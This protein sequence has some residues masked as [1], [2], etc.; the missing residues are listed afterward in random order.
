[1]KPIFH[2]VQRIDK[3]WGH[4]RVVCNNE[5]YCG[6]F[7]HFIK[8]SKFSL[9]AH[10]KKRETFFVLYGKLLL[11]TIN[12]ETAE[13]EYEELSAGNVVEIPR[14][15]P[16]QISALETSEI[17]EFSTHHEDSDSYRYEKGD[18]QR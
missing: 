2:E 5:E 11:R 4:E 6:K 9:H 7:L 1:M 8:G 15:L 14:G 10:F 17:V 13:S 3:G 18:S 12:T 16:H